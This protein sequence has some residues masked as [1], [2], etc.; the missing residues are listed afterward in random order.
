LKGGSVQDLLQPS[1]LGDTLI[2]IPS[3]EIQEKIG[4]LVTEAYEKKD[5]ANLIENEAIKLLENKL[6]ELAG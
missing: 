1:V 3:K 5:Q 6:K 4:N 2:P